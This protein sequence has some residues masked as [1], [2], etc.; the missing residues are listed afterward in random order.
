MKQV[1]SRALGGALLPPGAAPG[2]RSPPGTEGLI[3]I[4]AI[5][6]DPPMTDGR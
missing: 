4:S 1:Q 5:Q 2:L 3:L 6:P